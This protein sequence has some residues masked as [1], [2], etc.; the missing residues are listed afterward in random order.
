MYI[1]Q[2]L[3]GIH[4]GQIRRCKASEVY[5]YVEDKI[6]R[7]STLY[8]IVCLFQP[9]FLTTGTHLRKTYSSTEYHGRSSETRPYSP[10]LRNKTFSGTNSSSEPDLLHLLTLDPDKV[11]P[12]GKSLIA[13]ITQEKLGQSEDSEKTETTTLRKQVKK[14]MQKAFWDLVRLSSTK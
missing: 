3:Q 5:V 2:S 7:E 6:R 4:W 11:L 14:V 8:M 10:R 1:H 12:P 13:V 9:V